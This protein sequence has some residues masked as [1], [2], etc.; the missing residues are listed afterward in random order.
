MTEAP[1]PKASK[2]ST[3]TGLLILLGFFV[4]IFP[5]F[6]ASVLM[7]SGVPALAAKLTAP[8]MCPTPYADTGVVVHVNHPYAGKT[9]AT[10]D[11][12][13][14]QPDGLPLSV[15]GFRIAAALFIEVE[16]FCLL[17]FVVWGIWLAARQRRSGRM[18]A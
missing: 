13:C 4:V 17:A 11:W 5:G 15:S 18:V 7:T 1:A 16:L 2:S 3:P 9:V 12:Y 10:Y 14:R 6:M 8:I